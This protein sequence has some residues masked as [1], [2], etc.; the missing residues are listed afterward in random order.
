[1]RKEEFNQIESNRIDVCPLVEDTAPKWIHELEKNT[2]PRRSAIHA[3]AGIRILCPCSDPRSTCERNGS[4]EVWGISPAIT[5][6]SWQR[7]R[8]APHPIIV[9][10][11][12]D[13]HCR[14]DF[15][16]RTEP[17]SGS[18]HRLAH[19]FKNLPTTPTRQS[20]TIF[21]SCHCALPNLLCRSISNN[22]SWRSWKKICYAAL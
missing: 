18:W 14:R 1:M 13:G 11:T 16:T 4:S 22:K 8:I 2:H 9:H 17:S 12:T 7:I 20:T 21:F 10:K 19:S 6:K 5:W 15:A 3:T